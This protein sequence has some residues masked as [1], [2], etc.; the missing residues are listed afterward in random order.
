MTLEFEHL[1]DQM[2][3]EINE[4]DSKETG[5]AIRKGIAAIP[6]ALQSAYNKMKAVIKTVESVWFRFGAVIARLK[7]NKFS[8]FSKKGNNLT[9]ELDYMKRVELNKKQVPM[10]RHKSTQH[11]TVEGYLQPDGRVAIAKM[12]QGSV[13]LLYVGPSLFNKNLIKVE[14]VINDTQRIILQETYIEAMEPHDREREYTAV[15]KQTDTE[16]DLQD[17]IRNVVKEEPRTISDSTIAISDVFEIL[18]DMASAVEAGAG[19][20][21][22]LSMLLYGPPG[23]GK[24]EIITAFFKKRGYKITLLP[25][26]HVPIE[27]M[28]GYPVIDLKGELS[29]GEPGVKMMVSDVLPKG[30]GLHLLFL[31][32]FNA[33]SPEQ[34][35]ASMNLAL[36]GNIGT[37][38]LP[39]DTVVIAAG[40]AGEI[41]K[42]TAVN[43]LDAPTLRRFTYKVRVEPDLAEWLKG[44]ALKDQ[45]VD[46]EGAKI[47]TGPVLSIISRNLLKWSE[48][49]KNP[50]AAFRKVMHGFDP[51][52][53]DAGWLDPATWTK[54]DRNIKFRGIKEYKALN[55]EQKTKLIDIGKQQFKNMKAATDKEKLA[56]GSR[57]Y[58][59]G[60]QDEIFKRIAPHI[61]GAESE[62]IVSEMIVNY[63]QFKREK[64]SSLDILLNY[65]AVRDKAKKS[66]TLD[67]EV[68]LSEMASEIV[69]FG[70]IT[71]MKRYMKDKGVKY[72]KATANDP[73]A[74]ALLN[75]D[76]FIQDLNVGA[77][78]VTAH[79][80]ALAP[81]LEL[82]NQLVID[83]KAGLLQL[84]NKRIKAG[85]DGFLQSID[86]Q[87]KDIA[88]GNDKA[89]F[90]EVRKAGKS[91]TPIIQAAKR[92]KDPEL[93][94]QFINTETKNFILHFSKGKKKE[95]KE[96]EIIVKDERLLKEMLDLAG[97][98]S[99]KSN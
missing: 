6:Q 91:Y 84:G 1:I 54:L 8:L 2:T 50:Q 73:L 49:E 29:G 96:E 78:I 17:L 24:S 38:R 4:V 87:F 33:G 81:S 44:F 62:E 19:R 77:E 20:K 15:R 61:L 98:E 52:A 56:I 26:Q 40:N 67:A 75:V 7:N 45:I 95:R 57:T 58:I 90:M 82:K 93:K 63:E 18:E 53:E 21:E 83:W 32:E 51:G 60:K 9:G 28:A 86:K 34:M 31:D 43:E 55:D 3:C 10:Y 99:W 11:G 36:T 30:K 41:D 39:E 35:K 69:N 94:Q 74:Q 13:P 64:V 59:V 70:S 65:K 85:W 76:Q 46:Y 68:L 72:Y 71:A 14:D 27:T 89:K 48:E 16:F 47:N 42:A 37:Y 88:T 97:V 12:T 92:I 79:F 25:I 22:K 23:V 80:E 66:T 5:T